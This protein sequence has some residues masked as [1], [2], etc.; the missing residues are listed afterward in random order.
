MNKINFRSL[1]AVLTPKEMKNILGGTC[2]VQCAGTTKVFS[3][4]CCSMADCDD[5]AYVICGDS[6]WGTD[7]Y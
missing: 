1:E 4:D 3:I 5:K 6:G 2:T 7:C